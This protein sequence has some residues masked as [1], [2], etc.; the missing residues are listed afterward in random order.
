MKLFL[1]RLKLAVRSLFLHGSLGMA[2]WSLSYVPMAGGSPE[3]D[4]APVR[5]EYRTAVADLHASADAV[6]AAAKALDEAGEDDDRE[7][8]EATLKQ[9]GDDLAAARAK[10][11]QYQARIELFE[12]TQEARSIALPDTPELE[13]GGDPARP[14]GAK[15]ELTYRRH[16]EHSLFRDLYNRDVKHDSAAAE[17]LGRHIEEMKGEGAYDL[18]T[19]TD[20]AGGALVA[21]LY[22]QEE[23]VDR[24]TAGRVIADAIGTRELPPNTDSINLPKINS[25][26]GVEE[27]ADNEAVKETDATFGMLAADVKTRAGMQDV[28]QQLVD[29]SVPGIDEVIYSDLVKEYAVR[30]D[31]GVINSAVTNNKGLL[32]VTGINAVTYT[33]AS[34]TLGELY[35]K[36]ANGVGLIHEGIFLPGDAIFMA[37]RRWAWCLSAQDESKRPLI[38]PYAPQNAAGSTKGAVATGLVGDVQGLPVF[39]DPNIPT[40][41]GAGTNEDRIIIVRRDELYVWEDPAGPYLETFRDV[42]SGTLQVRFRLHNYWAQLNA[43]RPKAISVVSGTGLATPTF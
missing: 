13:A 7:A 25:G 40:N 5:E 35:P 27:Q 14:K 4:I 26:T 11:D 23:F 9:A 36:I 31:V 38:T 12:R 30:L 16:G 18:S 3:L 2:R 32:Q 42:G 37:P 1:T 21:P 24:A 20:E 28:P 6:D 29:R 39:V 22:L 17:R 33:D 43:R 15:S 34:P 10:A 8:L 41:L 19:A